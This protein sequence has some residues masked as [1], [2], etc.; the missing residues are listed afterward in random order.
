MDIAHY[1]F[2]ISTFQEVNDQDL[3]SKFPAV[4]DDDNNTKGKF[5]ISKWY[6]SNISEYVH[7]PLIKK[8]NNQSFIPNAIATVVNRGLLSISK[9]FL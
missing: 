9:I 7:I 3:L 1:K 5:A 8:K 4:T 2:I 6:E